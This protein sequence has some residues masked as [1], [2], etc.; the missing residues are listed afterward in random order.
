[1]E[2]TVACPLDMTWLW[3]TLIHSSYGYLHKAQAF[4]VPAWTEGDLEKSYW[5]LRDT[6]GPHQKIYA[7]GCVNIH[8]N[9][10][11]PRAARSLKDSDCPSS[12]I[13]QLPIDLLMGSLTIPQLPIALWLSSASSRW[14]GHRVGAR[15]EGLCVRSCSITSTLQPQRRGGHPNK[16]GHLPGAQPAGCQR[17]LPEACHSHRWEHQ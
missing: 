12:S 16:P 8:W 1:M 4:S 3:H 17:W 10:N 5:Q 11:N 9:M 14:E 6:E 15:E 13:A 2:R 7:H